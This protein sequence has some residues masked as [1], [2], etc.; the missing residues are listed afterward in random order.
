MAVRVKTDFNSDSTNSNFAK[1]IYR[2]EVLA[3]A[4][5]L[6]VDPYMYPYMQLYP[7]GVTMIGLQVAK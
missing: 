7:I 1:L 2:S 5:V 3:E 6:S 4:L